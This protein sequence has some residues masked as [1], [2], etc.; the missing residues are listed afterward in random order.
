MG[1]V[2]THLIR[3][4]G[5]ALALLT[6]AAMMF[7]AAELPRERYFGMSERGSEIGLIFPGGPADHAGIRSGDHILSIDGQNL[8]ELIDPAAVLRAKGP[9]RGIFLGLERNG[10]PLQVEVLP[11]SLPISEIFW[12]RAHALIALATILVGALIL[13]RR[14]GQLAAVFFATCLFL[15]VLIFRPYILPNAF[16]FRLDATGGQLLSTLL[17]GLLVHFFLLFP[18][19]RPLLWRRPWLPVAI[20]LPGVILFLLALP[21]HAF[22]ESRG[23]DPALAAKVVETGAGVNF[24]AA[25]ILS[26]IVFSRTYR[27]SPL[28]TVR[29]KLT[30]TLTGT[31]LGLLPLL[32]LMALRT[33]RPGLHIPADRTATLMVFFLPASFGY[34]ILRHGVFEIEFIVKR[35]LIYSGVAAALILLYFTLH[36]TLEALFHNAAGVSGWLGN[37]LTL[38]FLLIL[39]SPLRGRMQERIDRWVYPDRFEI[40][41]AVKEASVQLREASGTDRVESAVLATMQSLLS[42]RQVALFRPTPEN[43][44]FALAASVVA[45]GSEGKPLPEGLQV[46]KSL[47]DPLF[48]AGAPT[49]RE[50]LEAELP[51][52]FLPRQDLEAL[53]ACEARVLVPL[54]SGQ[55]RLGLVILGP[56][57]YREPY[58]RPDL[59]ALEELQTQ[60]ALALENASFAR[61]NVGREDIRHE[62]EV[63]RSIQ[64]QL[65]PREL[66]SFSS[67]EIA[68]SNLP[69]REI[70]G[71]YYDCLETGAEEL[72]VAIGDVS[73]KG[74]PAA[75]LMAN[76]QATF[77]AEA[78]T[79]RSPR[80]VLE[81]MNRRLCTIDAPERFVSF[82]CG[83]LDLARRQLAYAN[84]GHF[85]PI[86]AHAGGENERLDHGGLLLGI[87]EDA[88]YEGAVVPLSPGDLLVLFTDGVIERGGPDTRFGEPELV[89]AVLQKRHLSAADLLGW[90]NEELTRLCGS[91]VEDDTTIM[92]VK[93]L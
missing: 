25:L 45:P 14:E 36:F 58:S 31:L 72:T 50:D 64:A 73:G 34:A 82:F 17:P 27:A 67:L 66:P 37:G 28:P 79:G 3:W 70:G 56:R 51:F 89:D 32:L 22:W 60:A 47:A 55:R 13:L 61:E 41:R 83:R 38:L 77:R 68:A 20:Y 81:R 88:P 53:A 65:L 80:E 63:A 24:L 74:V 7:R 90:I 62:M 91:T 86:L 85:Q 21:G 76:V 12:L 9:D 40:R 29:R 8:E 16:G 4:L 75:L 46:G 44:G 49:F 2:R 23:L 19:E 6:A 43:R 48:A 52:G 5:T 78:A 71:D 35:S 42:V 15:A 84:A 1:N 26:V 69:C 87:H 92:V 59:E 57:S 54:T 30:V 10:L 33:V 93:M 39:M 18:F 11:E